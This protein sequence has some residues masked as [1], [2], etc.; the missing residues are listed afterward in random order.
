LVF[1]PGEAKSQLRTRL[2]RQE[3]RR[4]DIR[5]EPTDKMTDRQ[6]L[7]KVRKYFREQVSSS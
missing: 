3:G 5:V 1:G 2:A 4:R 6:I 7:A